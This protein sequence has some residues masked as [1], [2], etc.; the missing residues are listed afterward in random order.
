MYSLECVSNGYGCTG[1]A[2]VHYKHW[3][4]QGKFRKN[5]LNVVKQPILRHGV[6]EALNSIFEG[7]VPIWPLKRLETPFFAQTYSL[8]CVSNGSGC[9]EEAKVHYKHWGHQAKFRK[10]ALNLVKQ[11]IIVPRRFGGDICL[12][13]LIFA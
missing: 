12:Y 1:E 13:F 3:G 7:F 2:K 9:S 11:P 6:L 5:A 4:N 10:N 8:Q